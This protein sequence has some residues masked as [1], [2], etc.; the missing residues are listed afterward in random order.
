MRFGSGV[1]MAQA[2]GY[3]S[4]SVPS[5]GTSRCCRCSPKKTGKKERQ[6]ERE[7][8]R[9]RKEGKKENIGYFL[10]RRF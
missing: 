3:S 7:R 2:G 5:L 9:E 8:E 6:R 10:G 1:A 4:N